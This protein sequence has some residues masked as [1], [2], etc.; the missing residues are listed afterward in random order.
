MAEKVLPIKNQA[1]TLTASVYDASN[2]NRLLASPTLVAGDIQI[3]SD[4]GANW[5]TPTN[6]ATV[7]GGVISLVLTATEMNVD[8]L[9]VRIADQDGPAWV[10]RV[11]PLETVTESFAAIATHFGEIK[12][13]AFDAGSDSL[14]AMATT[15]EQLLTVQT[16]T[17]A[18]VDAVAIQLANALA[19]YAALI[20]NN[21]S[22][23]DDGT[24]TISIW[25]G[26]DHDG[27]ARDQIRFTLYDPNRDLSAAASAEFKV[28][29]TNRQTNTSTIK[30]TET[31][32]ITALGADLY[33]VVVDNVSNTNSSLLDVYKW[34]TYGVF[35]T[36]GSSVAQLRGG[37]CIAKNHAWDADLDARMQ[38][39]FPTVYL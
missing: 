8:E 28:W 1:Y 4:A 6:N 12:N 7:D 11:I 18:Q 15:L 34:Y 2:T 25:I 27:I 23:E 9:L 36:I 21:Q 19:A 32:T 33:D 14:H 35:C 37:R 30:F 22:E 31:V 38:S 16:E 17:V 5:G 29:E 3:S 39:G 24:E 13:A 20:S 10:D 26:S